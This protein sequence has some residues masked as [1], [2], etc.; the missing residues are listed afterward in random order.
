MPEASHI[1]HQRTRRRTH[2]NSGLFFSLG[3]ST[4]L[5]LIVAF[6]LIL[7]ATLYITLVTDLPSPDL[8]I[9]LMD[10]EDGLLNHPTLL[11]DRSG[12]Q[13]IATLRHPAARK[14]KYLYLPED[15]FGAD[16]PRLANPET[17][18]PTFF[19]RELISA[20]IAVTDPSFWEHT[21]FSFDGI[22]SDRH[23]TLA[24]QLVS[25]L[26]LWEEPT[27]LQSSLRERLLA[28][29]ITNRYGRAQILEW[30]LNAAQYGTMI[31]GADAA[32]WVYFGKSAS[33]INLAEAV[34]L[35]FL[36]QNP[37]L[38]PT[39]DQYQAAVERLLSSGA[40]SQTD[41]DY[42]LAHIPSPK[43]SGSIYT[44]IAPGFSDY[45][46]D[47]ISQINNLQRIQRG[48]LRITTSLN[49]PL[50]LQASC[51]T[52]AHLERSGTPV[53]DSLLPEGLDCQAERLLPTLSGPAGSPEGQLAAN[54]VILDPGTGQILA[55]VEDPNS[56]L[57][58]SSLP[59]HPPASLLTPF[60]YL[61]SFTRGFT[62]A[63]LVWDISNED[64]L[65]EIDSLDEQKHGPM[66][67]RMALAN[68]ILVPAAQ[69]MERVGPE[70]I[71]RT[72]RQFG[73]LTSSDELDSLPE[74]LDQS[75]L[76]D[77]GEITLLSIVQAMGVFANQGVLAGIPTQNPG[78]A[79][80][81]SQAIV[82]PIVILAIQETNQ[83]IW[84]QPAAGR[85]Q[86]ILS[87]QLAYLITN[88]LSD[89]AARWLTLGH[90]NALEIGR[91]AAA[92]LGSSAAGQDVWAVGYTPQLVIG[93]WMGRVSAPETALPLSPQLPAALWHALMQNAHQELPTESW[94]IPS[95]ITTLEVCDPSGML[96]SPYC[97]TVVSEIF[98]S[99]TE[100]MQVDNLYQVV[101]VNRET[102]LLAT[103]YT[104]SEL[105]EEKIF[106]Q[107]P[108]EATTWAHQ[109]GIPIP[110]DSYDVFTSNVQNDQNA[111]IQSP[112][113]FSVVGGDVSIT[114][115]AAGGDFSYYR[116]QLGQGLN[117]AAWTQIGEDVT[118]PA[119]NAELALWDTSGL[120]GLYTLQLLVVR[121]DQQIDT[122]T[123]QVTVDNQAP[124]VTIVYPQAGQVL[125]L[126]SI[127]IQV[128]AED[129]LQLKEVRILL[130]NLLIA[131]LDQ[132]PFAVSWQTQ[133]GEHSLL[134]EA[135]D[136]AGNKTNHKL[137]FTIK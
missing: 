101:K 117:P 48:G 135:E 38:P 87:T 114:G 91:P 78:D 94:Q 96:P 125:D 41:A 44:S 56:N 22:S 77:G 62:P 35:A 118:R 16:N 104:P 68:D 65:P 36:A 24:Q 66:R 98:L 116:I 76:L 67:L 33:I 50:Q 47:R 73:L 72:I 53:E 55:Y 4:L 119:R 75:I 18:G 37:N 93:V 59:G 99:G 61:T 10:G 83:H 121:E 51:A 23:P 86:P 17:N 88:I 110:P 43:V 102:G 32:A 92:K 89:E 97:P 40:I 127:T 106:L 134:V 80:E 31:Y 58:P 13:V 100:P 42:A 63:S 9:S 115:I 105:V 128:A 112:G 124:E 74:N 6:L 82:E 5:S 132:P 25:D 79:Q 60:I 113:M 52:Y 3:C 64:V 126:P 109:A 131:R 28:A 29:Q 14:A 103:I 111:K 2:P 49:F 120:S 54:V 57:D 39:P 15:I 12:E 130:D 107:I 1:V 21:G 45:V 108:R 30:Y 71:Y 81:D 19:S 69:V 20:S 123:I 90:P 136:Q 46:L 133:V 27:G 85:N 70:N 122:S 8:L 26:L 129:E 7:S 95:G 84:T 11:L 137:I 34:W